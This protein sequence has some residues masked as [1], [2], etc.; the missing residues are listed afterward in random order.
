VVEQAGDVIKR[1]ALA[2]L[3]AVSDEHG[4]LVGVVVCGFDLEVRVAADQRATADEQLGEDRGGVGLGVGGDLRNDRAGQPVI[5]DRVRRRGPASGW[6]WQ[7]ERPGVT[8][9]R[10]RLV[11]QGDQLAGHSAVSSASAARAELSS[12]IDLF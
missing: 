11:K 3:G 1:T 12:Q 8:G 7:R 9:R 2:S 6:W 4:E 5:G 10:R